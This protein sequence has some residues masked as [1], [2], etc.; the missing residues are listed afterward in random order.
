MGRQVQ[1][2]PTP[3]SAFLCAVRQDRQTDSNGEGE[4]IPRENDTGKDNGLVGRA[5][6]L[7]HQDQTIDTE[8]RGQST[9]RENTHNP[10][11]LIA[12]HLQRP[13]QGQRHHQDNRITDQTDHR[14]GNERSLLI[15]TLD[16]WR[17]LTLPV[18]RHRIAHEDLDEFGDDV[19]DAKDAEEGVDAD[20]LLPVRA[21]DSDE[22]VEEGDFHDQGHGA[23]DDCCDVSV[24]QE[25][26]GL[27]TGD[28]LDVI[29]SAILSHYLDQCQY[30]IANC[31]E[32]VVLYSQTILTPQ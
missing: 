15:Q 9:S 25:L 1:M 24:F 26:N 31:C 3:P 4:Y 28:V 5:T 21:E 32:E 8:R 17:C 29:S 6:I 2:I 23:V 30:T 19:V 18:C 27:F 22:D 11:L 7:N 13:G 14:V 20:D 12:G 10:Q 16:S